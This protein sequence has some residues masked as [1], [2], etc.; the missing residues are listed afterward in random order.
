M[1]RRLSPYDRAARSRSPPQL[2]DPSPTL[3]WFMSWFD[4]P[5]RKG[6]VW[7]V[8]GLLL[9]LA[10]MLSQLAARPPQTVA[11]EEIGET[12]YLSDLGVVES[13]GLA[14]SNRAAGLFWTH[15]DSGHPAK[16]F[17]LNRS[18]TA[19]GTCRLENAKAV[20]F[21]DIASYVQ[22]GVARLLV[23][24]V[25]DNRAK[26]PFVSL[27]FFDEPNPNTQA[28]VT[29]WFRID[30]RYPGGAHDCEAVAVDIDAG[31][32]ILVS[33]TFLPWAAIYELDLPP[34]GAAAA[35]QHR[36]ETPR[37]VGY[38]PLPL[39]TGMDRDEQNGDILL[40]NYFHLLRYPK[41][42]DGRPWWEQTPRATELPK[43]KQIEAVAV[44]HDGSIW[45]TSE[46]S[47]AP[48]ARVTETPE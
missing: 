24:D 15:N 12:V 38:L 11:S 33:K 47:P 31:K 17:A 13:S 36:E 20:D 48:L 19:T 27:Y 39:A 45:V 1:R 42:E 37:L 23:A 6:N 34:R 30:L 28:T 16:L 40:V 29:D 44:D 10:V 41:P 14:K 25:G 22:D 5:M 26:R 9:A 8:S 18:G 3:Y 21:E 4:S 46:G 2:P 7:L 35:G 32:V 43:L